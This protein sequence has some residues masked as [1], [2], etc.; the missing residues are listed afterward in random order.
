MELQTGELELQTVS[1]GVTDGR[2]WSYRRGS[3]SYQW[4]YRRLIL[5]SQTV[6]LELPELFLSINWSCQRQES[7]L[8]EE[9]DVNH[10]ACVNR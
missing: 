6:V 2:L 3:W 9:R 4:S 1:F 10:L 7:E 5:E 8:P